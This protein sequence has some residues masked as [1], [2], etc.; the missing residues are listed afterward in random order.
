MGNSMAFQTRERLVVIGGGMAGGKVVEE[1][2]AR[3][4]ERFQITILGAEPYTIY[5]RILLSDVLAG[6]KSPEGVFLYSTEWFQ[7][8][9]IEL[10]TGARVQLI[11]R[12]QKLLHLAD[13]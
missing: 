13:D 2:V 11:D 8:R 10:F 3:D 12:E 5:N 9:G 4:P 6:V 7:S 1:I